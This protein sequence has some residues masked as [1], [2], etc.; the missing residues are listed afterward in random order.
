ML[1]LTAASKIINKT[2]HSISNITQSSINMQ[3]FQNSNN[4]NSNNYYSAST[5]AALASSASSSMRN[6]TQDL[7]SSAR[8]AVG[9]LKWSK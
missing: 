4:G 1:G 9:N 8:S 7:S 3:S 2:A 6:L 5:A